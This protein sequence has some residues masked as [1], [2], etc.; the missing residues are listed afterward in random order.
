MK[1]PR[2]SSLSRQNPQIVNGHTEADEAI[3]GSGEA[4]AFSLFVLG[5]VAKLLLYLKLPDARIETDLAYSRAPRQFKGLGKRR[6]RLAQIEQ[7]YDRHIV[8]PAVLDSELSGAGS[9]EAG[10]A[11]HEKRAHWGRPHFKTQPYGPQSS[12]RKVIFVGPVIVRADRL[13]L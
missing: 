11:H 10:S 6:E 3:D 1:P 13:N 7:L 12:L 4:R 8:G 2:P 5:Y 9:G